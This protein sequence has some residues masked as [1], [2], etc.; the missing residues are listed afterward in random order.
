MFQI[1]DDIWIFKDFKSRPCNE[2]AMS[3]RMKNNKSK[4]QNKMKYIYLYNLLSLFSY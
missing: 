1:Q 3:H 4:S 2:A